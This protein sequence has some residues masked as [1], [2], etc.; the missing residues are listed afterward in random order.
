MPTEIDV[1]LRQIRDAVDSVREQCGH[2]PM[3]IM[4]SKETVDLIERVREME[5]GPKD[6]RVGDTVRVEFVGKIEIFF[7]GEDVGIKNI[8][9]MTH[10]IHKDVCTIISRPAAIPNEPEGA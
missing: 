2:E 4:A 10:I 3:V 1:R 9:G 7:D 6:I 5:H 8:N